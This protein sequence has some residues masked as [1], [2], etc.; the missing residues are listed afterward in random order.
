M[1]RG[2]RVIGGDAPPDGGGVIL[3]ACNVPK[4]F[5]LLA[6]SHRLVPVRLVLE[7]R[8]E[9]GLTAGRDIELPTRELVPQDVIVMMQRAIESGRV[10]PA[11][12]FQIAD[13]PAA[14]GPQEK[15]A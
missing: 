11:I 1:S 2:L 14:P 10:V 9:S 3:I 6:R 7:Q 15:G 5:A 8:G 12:A 4:E 13:A